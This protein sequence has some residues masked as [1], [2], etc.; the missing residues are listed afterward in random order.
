M[1]NLLFIGS[2]MLISSCG[3]LKTPCE[4]A[5]KICPSYEELRVKDTIVYKD[6]VI[7]QFKTVQKDSIVI[8][9]SFSAEQEIPCI[10]GAKT[11]IIR[12]GDIFDVSV[13]DGKVNLK[14]NLQGTTSRFSSKIEEK[15]LAIKNLQKQVS[16]KEKIETRPPIVRV[17]QYI[18]WWVK[19]LAWIGAGSLILLL[20]YLIIKKPAF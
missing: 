19:V 5:E 8:R 18:P 7:F 9:D 3:V 1:K 15:E 10:D 20:I 14:V 6:S 2:L 11:R 12:G 16:S 17:Q 13:K 4:R